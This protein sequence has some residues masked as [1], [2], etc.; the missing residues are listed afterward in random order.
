MRVLVHGPWPKKLGLHRLINL[1][2]VRVISGE[3]IMR[4]AMILVFY[5]FAFPCLAD[6]SP[7]FKLSSTTSVRVK[8]LDDAKDGCW[9]NLRET[10]EY[11]E[12]KLRLKGAN[13]VPEF[14]Y[15][16]HDYQFSVGVVAGRLNINGKCTA[17]IKLQL[18]T[19]VNLKNSS[20]DYVTHFA[21][22][23]INEHLIIG[24]N[25]VNNNVL[26]YVKVFIDQLKR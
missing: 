9:T 7:G 17:N 16:D 13:I 3:R 8:L 21:G 4:I 19:M 23:H 24:Y 25:K 26:D 2:K 11:A 20:G 22:V 14:I 18:I 6:P 5:L 10:R 12:E 15:G 1:D